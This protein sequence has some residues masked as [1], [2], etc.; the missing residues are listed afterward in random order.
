MTNQ[1]KVLEEF[2]MARGLVRVEFIEEVGG[3]LNFKRKQFLALMNAIGWRAIK[4]LIL[5]HCDRIDWSGLDSSGSSTMPK[6]K[7]VR[8][9]Y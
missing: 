7:A 8:C 1:R 9:W 3:G 4:T 5:A 2:A 6:P